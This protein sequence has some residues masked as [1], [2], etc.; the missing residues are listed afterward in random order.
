MAGRQAGVACSRHILKYVAHLHTFDYGGGL[1]AIVCHGWVF[2]LYISHGV[3]CAKATTAPIQH[4]H[5]HTYL[6]WT[7]RDGAH[8]NCMHNLNFEIVTV[9]FSVCVWCSSYS[10]VLCVFATGTGTPI[11][12]SCTDSDKVDREITMTL[13]TEN[14]YHISH[15]II[16][17]IGCI[18]SLI[19]RISM[20][21]FAKH[22]INIANAVSDLNIDFFS[23]FTSKPVVFFSVHHLLKFIIFLFCFI[24]FSINRF[25]F[26][27]I[28]T[29]I[30]IVD[31]RF[32][33]LSFR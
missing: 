18:L 10:S 6:N 2:A 5:T 27:W 24:N 31:V 26:I 15:N 22:V 14:A 20:L 9:F 23:I 8:A 30:Y 3:L 11:P 17:I 29:L 21:M 25:L 16:S 13:S 28:F 7:D 32:L 4:T 12:G 33:C 1:T 19:F